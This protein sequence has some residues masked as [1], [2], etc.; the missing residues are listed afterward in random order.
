MLQQGSRIKITKGV[1]PS[2]SVAVVNAC[3]L[4]QME[5]VRSYGNSSNEGT[6]FAS[7]S[8]KELKTSSL[9]Q[10]DLW[11]MRLFLLRGTFSGSTQESTQTGRSICSITILLE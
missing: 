2:L 11:V 4:F 1:S 3:Y 5:D 8:G 6:L 9:Y 10:I 7:D